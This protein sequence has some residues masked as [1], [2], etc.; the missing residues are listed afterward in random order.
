MAVENAWFYGLQP[1]WFTWDRLYKVYLLKECIVGAY[2]A[3]QVYDELSGEIQ[4]VRPAFILAPLMSMWVR[5]IVRKRAARE[6]HYDSLAPDS[7]EFLAADSRNFRIQ[8][9]EVERATVSRARALW[10]WGAS[11]SGSIRI[12]LR[13]GEQRRFILVN[14][15]DVARIEEALVQL[16]GGNRVEGDEGR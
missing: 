6:E 8:A 12:M 1:R 4:L 14:D 13:S 15:Q 7:E 3:G 10:T 9:D 16:L 5:R 11:N 2:L